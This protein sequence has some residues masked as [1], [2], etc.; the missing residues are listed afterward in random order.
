M[1]NHDK[2]YTELGIENYFLRKI[3]Q[4]YQNNLQIFSKHS[5]LLKSLDLLRSD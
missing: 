5:A 1:F 3:T 4:S 2:D